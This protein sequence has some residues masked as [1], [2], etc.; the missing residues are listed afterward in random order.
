M[1]SRLNKNTFYMPYFD[2]FEVGLAYA[3]D[4]RRL[5]LTANIQYM[6]TNLTKWNENDSL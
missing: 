3:A 2:R 5:F 1:R 6:M 4:Y